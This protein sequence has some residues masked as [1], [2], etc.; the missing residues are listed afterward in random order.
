MDVLRPHHELGSPNRVAEEARVAGRPVEL[1]PD[2]RQLDVPRQAA[3]AP[4]RVAVNVHLPG[5]EAV[6]ANMGEHGPRGAL[7][8]RGVVRIAEDLSRFEDPTDR[9]GDRVRERR[10]TGAERALLEVAVALLGG[11]PVEVATRRRLDVGVTG[12][13]R[14]LEHRPRHARVVGMRRAQVRETTPGA[15]LVERVRQPR[16]GAVRGVEEALFVQLLIAAHQTEEHLSGV[17]DDAVRAVRGV[18]DRAVGILDLE[19]PLEHGERAVASVLVAEIVGDVVERLDDVAGGLAVRR[20]PAEAAGAQ[21]EAGAH[22]TVGRRILGALQPV[23]RRLEMLRRHPTL[24]ARPQEVV[25]AGRRERPEILRKAR[26]RERLHGSLLS[27]DRWIHGSSPPDRQRRPELLLRWR[28]NATSRPRSMRGGWA[29]NK[30]SGARPLTRTVAAGR[31]ASRGCL[32]DLSGSR[33]LASEAARSGSSPSVRRR[34]HARPNG[35]C[36]RPPRRGG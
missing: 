36:G 30:R 19:Q 27:N 7:R 15:V 2:H 25:R 22:P 5:D 20:P 18:R 13:G 28:F 16:R 1:E 32:S 17:E 3:V 35:R 23:D 34:L 11:G 9:V 10:E 12:S 4:V 21:G 8:D 24:R 14:V 6:F 29:A 31:R 33:A 26:M